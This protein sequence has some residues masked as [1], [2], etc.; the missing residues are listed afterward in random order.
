MRYVRYAILAI[1]AIVFVSIAMANRDQVTVE[2]LAPAF[3]NV[4]GR[5]WEIT[6]PLFL[7]MLISALG[8]LVF[9]FVWEW[10]REHKHRREA[11]R[12]R[13]EVK[14]LEREV[15]RL[16]DEKHAGKDEVLA[17]LDEADRRRA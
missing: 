14:R 17:I 10:I 8:G 15:G 4:V 7:V 12:R 11:G 5:N 2:L 16:T 9:G 1:L 13:R 3:E 6:L